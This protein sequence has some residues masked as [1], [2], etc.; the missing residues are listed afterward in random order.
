MTPNAPAGRRHR[1]PRARRP[2]DPTSPNAGVSRAG[3]RWSD[4]ARAH[5]ARLLAAFAL[6][7]ALAWIAGLT[8]SKR[9]D[10]THLRSGGLVM[11]AFCA[12]VVLTA[13]VSRLAAL[14]SA[15]SSETP[16]PEAL[17]DTLPD[18]PSDARPDDARAPEALGPFA[19]LLR[20]HRGLATPPPRSLRSLL[21]HWRTSRSDAGAAPDVAAPE[22]APPPARRAERRRHRGR[23]ERRHDASYASSLRRDH[24]GH[25]R[26]RGRRCDRARRRDRRRHDRRARA[27][28]RDADHLAAAVPGRVGADLRDALGASG[29]GPGGGRHRR[30]ATTARGGPTAA[31]ATAS[32]T[33]A[34]LA[35]GRGRW[36]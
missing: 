33:A 32:R 17:A 28:P 3:R 7:V 30:A 13:G 34:A 14:S 15:P 23:A 18:A 36:A 19:R 9:T 24:A 31:A 35:L 25:G 2:C 22:P 10:P 6:G 26:R 29:R 4:A 16:A 21:S 27:G 12:L 5:P 20:R 1:S 8:L 11:M